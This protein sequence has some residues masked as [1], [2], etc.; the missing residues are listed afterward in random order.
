MEKD[1]AIR[2]RFIATIE[3]FLLE[4]NLPRVIKCL[5]L[6]SEEQ[7]WFKPN[8]ASNS[9]GNLVLH[10]AGN[11]NQWVLKA[12]G[13]KNYKRKRDEEFTA[14]KT[15][16]KEELIEIL[17]SIKNELSTVINSVSAEELLRVR[18]VQIYEE[19]AITILIHVTEHFSYHTGQIAYITKWLTCRPTD[20]YGDLE[21]K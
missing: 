4:E 19:D 8:T 16:S 10:L 2:D 11:L 5:E 15:K 13:G 20:F 17:V 3:R 7:I 12:I 21:E 14:D 6:L 18:P 1:T 9:V